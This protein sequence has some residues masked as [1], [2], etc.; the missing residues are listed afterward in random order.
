MVITYSCTS[1][2][3]QNQL[4][5]SSYRDIYPDTWVATDAVGRTMPDIDSVGAVKTDK[6]RTVCI[7]Y[8]TI[9]SNN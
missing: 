8:I 4:D 7:F 6:D 1:S 2:I 3:T 9:V 5:D